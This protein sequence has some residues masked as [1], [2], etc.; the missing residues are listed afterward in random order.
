[1]CF[2]TY[3]DIPGFTHVWHVFPWH[4]WKQMLTLKNMCIHLV[5]ECITTYLLFLIKESLSIFKSRK[6][7]L[8]F[9]NIGMS[10]EMHMWSH[11]NIHDHVVRIT[12][13]PYEAAMSSSNIFGSNSALVFSRWPTM[14]SRIGLLEWLPYLILVYS[15]SLLSMWSWNGYHINVAF[16][17]TASMKGRGNK[18][19]CCHEA[20]MHL[21]CEQTCTE[22]IVRIYMWTSN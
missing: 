1:M 4:T 10:F 21:C 11:R 8:I 20:G 16:T 18:R 22:V 5:I 15:F 19:K 3:V 13:N 7:F 2:L 12:M 14:H 6:R 9:L 17:S